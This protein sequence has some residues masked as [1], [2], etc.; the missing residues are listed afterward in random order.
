VRQAA[1]SWGIAFDLAP[2]HAQGQYQGMHAMGAD[3]GK[4]FA[5]AIFTWLVLDHGGPG[6]IVLA[7]GFAV[8]GVAMP[9]VVSWG[10]RMRS[11]SAP[12]PAD[13]PAYA[14]S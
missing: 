13:D 4:M 5:P 12:E 1:G 3:I 6:W 7:V 8:L 9:A 10:L 14:E 11:G 2:D